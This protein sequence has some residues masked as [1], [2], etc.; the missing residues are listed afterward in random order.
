MPEARGSA[1]G[2]GVRTEVRLELAFH[3]VP[4]L[5]IC[6]RRA[7]LGDIGPGFGIL[8]IQA[9]PFFQSRLSI[10]LDGFR[11]AFRLANA[12][13]DTD[14]RIDHQHVLTLIEAVYRADLDAIHEFAFDAGISDNEGHKATPKRG[15]RVRGTLLKALWR[16]DQAPFR[17]VPHR[18]A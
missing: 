10:R 17:R 13:I 15:V 8:R 5:R 16:S 14:F 7:F 12:A 3:A 11:R 2:S 1:A 18:D 6:G 9:Q 4:F